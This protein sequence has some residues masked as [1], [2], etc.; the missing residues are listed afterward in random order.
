MTGQANEREPSA[1]T[2]Q[3]RSEQYLTDDLKGQRGW[4]ST[5]AS[6]YKTRGQA[7]SFAVIVA[8][9]ATSFLQVLPAGWL[10]AAP[11]NWVPVA[12]AALGA[13]V[14]LIEGWQRISRYNETWPG[15]R[16]ASERMKREQRLYVNGAGV[17]R[18]VEED[19]AYLRFVE[20]V[21]AAIAEEQQLYWKSRPVEIS[22]GTP[23]KS[24]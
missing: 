2:R 15:Y 19:E 13:M 23:P 12:T 1:G 3:A 6:A 21:E 8:G 14:V 5:R 20:A 10:P 16:A 7:C 22:I 18:G 24:P 11:A 9:A 17:Y 4:Y